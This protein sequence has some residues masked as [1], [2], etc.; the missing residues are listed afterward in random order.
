[1]V[2]V[3][4]N[5][6][7]NRK[8]QIC[9]Y[10]LR[11]LQAIIVASGTYKLFGVPDIVSAISAT[12]LYYTITYTARFKYKLLL[13]MCD[14]RY[15]IAAMIQQANFCEINNLRPRKITE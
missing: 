10:L 4:Q 12:L 9:S 8:L 5:S 1:M 7:T 6:V 13:F 14:K 2:C 11:K 15:T 3:K